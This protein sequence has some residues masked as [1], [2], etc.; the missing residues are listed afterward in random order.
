MKQGVKKPKK[1][2][3]DEISLLSSSNSVF[4][5]SD[6]LDKVLP[7]YYYFIILRKTNVAGEVRLIMSGLGLIRHLA[8]RNLMQF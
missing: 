6:D 2:K 3:F 5:K 4:S 8:W 7:N 1:I